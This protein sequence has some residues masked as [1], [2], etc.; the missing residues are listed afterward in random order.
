MQIWLHIWS[1][2][3]KQH[4]IRSTESIF[5]LSEMYVWKVWVWWQEVTS[6]THSS[7]VTF[8]IFMAEL[9]NLWPLAY[10]WSISV[11]SL[12]DSEFW[13]INFMKWKENRTGSD[14]RSHWHKTR[15]TSCNRTSVPRLQR[16]RLLIN[17]VYIFLISTVMSFEVFFLEIILWWFELVKFNITRNQSC[18]TPQI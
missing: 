9:T 5:V 17:H 7:R 4:N 11:S 13:L 1:K 8:D 3:R 15:S 18:T 14:Q 2:N 6:H 12:F 10:F 16:K